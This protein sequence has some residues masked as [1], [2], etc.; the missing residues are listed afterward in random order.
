MSLTE[1]NSI[2]IQVVEAD[3]RLFASHDEFYTLGQ[4]VGPGKGSVQKAD[5]TTPESVS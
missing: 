4:R 3:G 5:M 2:Q 1:E